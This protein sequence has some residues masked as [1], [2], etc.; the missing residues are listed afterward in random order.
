MHFH[1]DSDSVHG[2]PLDCMLQEDTAIIFPFFSLRVWQHS[3]FTEYVKQQ[4][5]I[6]WQGKGKEEEKYLLPVWFTIICIDFLNTTVSETTTTTKPFQ[7][8]LV[9]EGRQNNAFAM[10]SG[11]YWQRKG[12]GKPPSV[13]EKTECG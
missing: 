5:G 12:A 11:K 9:A 4:W 6:Q 7:I 10:G 1:C 3:L 2:S 13:E 8:A